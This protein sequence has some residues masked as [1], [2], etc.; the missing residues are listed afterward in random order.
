MYGV[1]VFLLCSGIILPDFRSFDK[2]AL[3]IG[4]ILSLTYQIQA[5]TMQVYVVFFDTPV[6]LAICEADIEVVL[7]RYTASAYFFTALGEGT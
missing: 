1:G 7:Y 6:C 2:P 5:P 3:F 4:N